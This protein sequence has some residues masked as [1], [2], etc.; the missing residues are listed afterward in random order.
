LYSRPTRPNERDAWGTGGGIDTDDW[1]TAAVVLAL[2]SLIGFLAL[3]LSP[4]TSPGGWRALFAVA[5]GALLG[6]VVFIFMALP[7]FLPT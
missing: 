5:A 4:P 6:S 7:A 3:E 2:A 1:V